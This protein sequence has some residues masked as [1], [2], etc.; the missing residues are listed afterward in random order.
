MKYI[1]FH[2][3]L[4]YEK[5]RNRR[6]E[7]VTQC[8]DNLMEA[9]VTVADP[10]SEESVE[11]TRELLEQDQ[12]ISTMIAAHPHEASSYSAEVEK[13]IL[14]FAESPRCIAIG[15]AG[16]DFHYNY[17]EPEVQLKLF[18]RQIEI[19][20]DAGLPLLIHSRNAES[21]VLKAIEECKFENP[22]V[23][24]CY[25]G[26]PESAEEIIKRGYYISISGIV[27]FKKASDLREVVKYVPVER[28]F[29][30]TDS[31]YLAPVPYRGKTNIPP[32]VKQVADYIAELKGISV[33]ELNRNIGKNYNFIKNFRKN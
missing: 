31:P 28:L 8:F 16:L 7:I 33:E 13:R 3:H 26:S 18:K 6:N 15:E 1:D 21:E 27:T 20:K 19:A 5:D 4:D 2:C 12:R 25:T 24:H 17:S 22:V 23:F 14:K 9:L 29:S 32:Y 10:Y 11:I 30:E